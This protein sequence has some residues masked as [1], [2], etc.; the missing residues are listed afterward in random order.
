MKNEKNM[1]V[2]YVYHSCCVIE[3]ETFSII[4]DYYKDAIKDGDEIGWVRK[5]ILKKKEPL[6]VLCTHSHGDHFNEEV[7]SW[8]RDKEDI[9]YV[10]SK[11]VVNT[12]KDTFSLKDEKIIYLDK[13]EEYKDEN[14]KIKAFGSTDAGAS[15]YIEHND[16]KIFHAGDLNNW[17]WNEEV[18]KEESFVFEN[19]YICELELLSEEVSEVDVAMFPLDPR[20]GKD[21]MLGGEQFVNKIKT[22]NFLPLHFGDNYEL[23]QEFE[24][25]ALAANCK[26]LKL[27]HKGQ[28]FKI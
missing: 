21:F 11:E 1:I 26:L 17:H 5:H 16:M 10:F 25:V 22:R 27:D 12:L 28:S 9:T 6:Y 14:L 3:F 15:F 13:L 18:S 7:L 8:S 19:Q 20:L 23:I 2:T 4:V 24:P